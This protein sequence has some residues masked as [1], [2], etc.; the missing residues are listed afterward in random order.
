M[1]D[2]FRK[3][4]RLAAVAAIFLL[5][6]V[7]KVLMDNE[8]FIA[9][10]PADRRISTEQR[11]ENFA[12]MFER[13]RR[14]LDNIMEYGDE[15]CSGYVSVK[16]DAEL[17][18]RIISELQSLSD[19]ICEGAETDREKVGR[20]EYWVADN[21]YYDHVAA[22]TAVTAEVISLET[23]LDTKKTTCAGYS[24]MF[25]ALCNMQGIYC[26]NLRGGTYSY[27]DTPENL[28]EAPMNHEWNAVL[29]DGEW[30]FIDTTWLSNN[31]YTDEYGYV[32]SDTMDEMYIDMTL[33][34]MS[35]EHRIDLADYR[36][37]KSSVKVFE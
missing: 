28:M 25:S 29:L 14:M 24:N 4:S 36:D 22:E 11:Y 13:N 17:H 21:I 30:V 3:K 8:L 23:V 32:Y 27:E 18:K 34:Y 26:V 7:L 1:K 15:Y 6:I 19:G 5:A 2:I 35:L 10:D 31:S 16:K 33:E 37:F 20:L 9:T 12:D